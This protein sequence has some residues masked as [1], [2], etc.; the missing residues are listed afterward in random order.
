MWLKGNTHA[1][2][3]RSDG[4]APLH[5]VA[6]WY[7]A[8]GYDF[9]IVTDHN[10]VTDVSDWNRGGGALLLVPGCELSL[11]A[12]GKPIH[13]NS[14]GSN[15]LPDLPRADTIA[16]L[17][18]KG[19]DAVR[20]AGG[21]PQI[22][23][24]N[25]EWAFTD[26]Q[27]RDVTNWRLLEIFNAG[28]DCNNLGGGGWPGVEEMWDRLLSTGRRIWGVASDDAHH[29]GGEWWEY[30][31]PP[32]GAWVV[33]RAEECSAE[34]ILR[35]MERG[36]FYASTEVTIED[37]VGASAPRARLAGSAAARDEMVVRIRQ[38]RDFRYTTRF[39]GAGGRTLATV[40]GLEAVYSPRGDEG[41]IRAKVFSSNGGVAWTQPVF[42]P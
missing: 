5:E 22:N 31:S 21:V 24:P 27:M 35:A 30:R 7:Q 2:T 3:N 4:D 32:G 13:I 23:H 1:H 20:E 38:Q 12:E 28:T 17:L 40:H 37:I 9:L 33:V 26:A 15:V 11:S 10:Q 42:L 29:L 14:L 39:I 34:A 8:R 19:V 18:Q 41:Y 16:V 6:G 25:Y 36:D